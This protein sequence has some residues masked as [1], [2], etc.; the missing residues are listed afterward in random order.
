MKKLVLKAENREKLGGS[1]SRQI[2]GQDYLPV[3]VYGPKKENLN[4]KVKYQEFV[5]IFNEAGE[6]Q[7]INLEVGDKNI[8]VLIHEVQ[9]EP[10][11]GK[12]TH[13]DFYQFQADHKFIVE[14]PIHLTGE[15]KAVKEKGATLVNVMDHIEVECLASN[16]IS[17]VSVDISKLEDYND[18]IHVSDLKVPEGV[19]IIT[20]K[21]QVI[22][23]AKANKVEEEP[24]EEVATEATE[25]K[26]EE[27]KEE[28]KKE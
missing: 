3:I 28:A 15:S 12:I 1:S 5:K 6:S 22:I 16:L 25:E 20:E 23:I 4:L 21:D 7:V 10:I 11:T 27:P 26:K 14:V 18:S 19:E 17:E 9:H 2:L 24:K 8:P 13:A